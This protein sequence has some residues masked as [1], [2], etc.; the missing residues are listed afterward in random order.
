MK[1]NIDGLRK[2]FSSKKFIV[3]IST[4]VGTYSIYGLGIDIPDSVTL[5]LIALVS[6]YL[7]SQAYADRK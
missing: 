3:L 5:A 2:A 4:V 7:P 6:V 1:M